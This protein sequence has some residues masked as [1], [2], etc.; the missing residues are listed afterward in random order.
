MKEDNVCPFF[1]ELLL[2]K[3][4]NEEY[5]RYCN[6]REKWTQGERTAINA[7]IKEWEYLNKPQNEN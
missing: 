2:E 7:R 5:D 6:E 4:L 3:Q 1:R